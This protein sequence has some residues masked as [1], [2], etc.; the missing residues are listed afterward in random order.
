MNTSF[1]FHHQ[2][3]L[4]VISLCSENQVMR[5]LSWFKLYQGDEEWKE[6]YGKEER[7]W[8]E[9]N[10][11][12]FSSARWCSFN[13]NTLWWMEGRREL[14]S[15]LEGE[16]SGRIMEEKMTQTRGDTRNKVQRA[17][18]V[19]VAEG[20]NEERKRTSIMTLVRT[21]LLLIN[22]LHNSR[23]VSGTPFTFQTVHLLGLNKDLSH[24]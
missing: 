15:I 19:K 24:V 17:K 16:K 4:L 14:S 10:R 20:E 1:L 7:V 6:E 3:S 8:D 12:S 23:R 9:I 21:F 13:S 18:R 5:S 2:V 22:S 11:I